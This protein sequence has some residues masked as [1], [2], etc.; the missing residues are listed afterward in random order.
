M[1]TINKYSDPEVDTLKATLQDLRDGHKQKAEGGMGKRNNS[2]RKIQTAEEQLAEDMRELMLSPL[3]QQGSHK[4]HNYNSDIVSALRALYTALLKLK[5]VATEDQDG[6]MEAVQVK[7]DAAVLAL[8][9]GFFS[10]GEG[11]DDEET[12]EGEDDKNA[13]DE[14][15]DGENIRASL[16]SKLTTSCAAAEGRKYRDD[17]HRAAKDGN[18]A[19]K[20]RSDAEDD[21][22]MLLDAGDFEAD[23]EGAEADFE[24]GDDGANDGADE[25][26]G[27]GD[28]EGGS[29]GAGEGNDEEDNQSL[30]VS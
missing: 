24:M 19:Y 3:H 7:L 29:R 1:S 18:K 11:D 5:A 8:H 30:F 10:K 28:G 16:V 2:T 26:G 17:M 6:E 14:D 9:P 13:M 15:E 12:S 4:L 27:N 23:D 21:A 20:D 22:E 25:D